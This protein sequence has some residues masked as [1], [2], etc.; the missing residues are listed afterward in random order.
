MK[1]TTSSS[2]STT[3]SSIQSRTRCSLSFILLLW[4][5]LIQSVLAG[6]ILTLKS[7]RPPLPIDWFI[8]H[9]QSI[10]PHLS[11]SFYKNLDNATASLSAIINSTVVGYGNVDSVSLIVGTPWGEIFD[12][13]VGKLRANDTSDT[14]TVNSDSMFRIGSIT[15][16]PFTL[17]R[18]D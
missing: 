7:C 8:N 3:S 5:F 15:K 16:V 18:I 11:D 12:H 10:P 1:T 14:R 17:I 2:S 4:T 9:F 6:E 13:H